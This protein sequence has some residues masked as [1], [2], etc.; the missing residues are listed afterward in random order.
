M[1]DTA[2]Q[3]IANAPFGQDLEVA[4]VEG[5]EVHR[6]IV[7]CRRTAIGWI[8]AATGRRIDVDPTH[9]RYWYR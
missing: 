3:T 8:N 6:L 7:A 5:D 2:W 1:C 4:V 9:W